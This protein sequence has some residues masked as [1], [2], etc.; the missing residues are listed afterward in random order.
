MLTLWL[1]V[2]K[3]F[4]K[5]WLYTFYSQ[6]NDFND[7]SM[8]MD[9]WWFSNA[10]CKSCEKCMY[11]TWATYHYVV[12]PARISLTLSRHSSLSFIASGLHAVSSQSCCMYVWAGCPAFCSAIW[13]SKSCIR[14]VLKENELLNSA[15]L[16]HFGILKCCIH[17]WI[18][19]GHIGY[20]KFTK[21]FA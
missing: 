1:F 19:S 18:E 6:L 14:C 20:W 9:S 5:F 12:S 10:A 3:T 15:L 4:W 2:L 8:L 11:S 17:L 16:K 7:S 21:L 13:G